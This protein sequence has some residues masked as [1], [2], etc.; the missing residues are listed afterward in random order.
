[1]GGTGEPWLSLSAVLVEFVGLNQGVTF[2][3]SVLNR[4]RRA[5]S[6]DVSFRQLT[7]AKNLQPP[8]LSFEDTSRL[9]K[10]H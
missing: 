1:M 8:V 3:H 6:R 9:A 2:E 10:G 4:A 7:T 5:G